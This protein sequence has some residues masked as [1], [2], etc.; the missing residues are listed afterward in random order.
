MASRMRWQAP[1]AVLALLAFA[2]AVAYAPPADTAP[3]DVADLGIAKSDS[4]DPV[5]VGA[6]LT[7]TIQVTNLGPQD[8]TGVTVTDELPGH[9]TFISA[10]ASAGSC[11]Q[12]GKRVTCNLGNLGV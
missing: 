4:P 12:K 2:V 3:G 9:V 5:L 8:A 7:Y 10:S 6:V 1:A 11:E